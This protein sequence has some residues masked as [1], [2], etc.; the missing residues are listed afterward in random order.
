MHISR[1]MITY[2]LVGRNMELLEVLYC[3]ILAFLV[4]AIASRKPFCKGQL[5]GLKR[6]Q[7][8]QGRYI[9]VVQMLTKI[10]I[11]FHYEMASWKQFL[12]SESHRPI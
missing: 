3:S 12:A 6:W 2:L 9:C 4:V 8:P 10:H 5:H 7:G 11:I 1:E